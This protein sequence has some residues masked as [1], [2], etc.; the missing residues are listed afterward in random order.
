MSS[1]IKF[2]KDVAQAM[3]THKFLNMRGIKSYLRERAPSTVASGEEPFV[4]DYLSFVTKT[5][6]R[7]DSSYCLNL[8][9]HGETSVLGNPFHNGRHSRKTF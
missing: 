1:R 8:A 3:E 7:Q 5:K 9:A 2:F 6:R 4:A